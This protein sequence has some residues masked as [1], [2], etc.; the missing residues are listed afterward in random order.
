MFKL[1]IIKIKVK[2][3]IIGINDNIIHLSPVL[4]EF[5]KKNNIIL[6]NISYKTMSKIIEYLSFQYEMIKS[7]ENDV[8][9][10]YNNREWSNNFLDIS[11]DELCEIANASY[12][13]Q[14]NHLKELIEL[15]IY[16]IVILEVFNKDDE[17]IFL[18]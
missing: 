8:T 17:R 16:S 6:K 18:V 3:G 15:K 1:S 11:I 7:N 9:K 10:Y 4:N 14:L 2:D 5:Y 12:D 13:L